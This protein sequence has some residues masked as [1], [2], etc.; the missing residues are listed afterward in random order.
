MA[1][2]TESRLPLDG[3]QAMAFHQ[4]FAQRDDYIHAE[5]IDHLIDGEDRV[6]LPGCPKCN[7]PAEQV[8]WTT[9]D[10]WIGVDIDPCGHRCRVERPVIHTSTSDDGSTTMAEWLP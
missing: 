4:A 3:D 10:K 6:P 9:H 8:L 7:R 2:A 1:A 5:L